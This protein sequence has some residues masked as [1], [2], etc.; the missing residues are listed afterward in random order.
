MRQKDCLRAMHRL[1]S[2]CRCA[3]RE[4]VLQTS[5]LIPA[6]IFTNLITWVGYHS[7][8]IFM[9]FPISRLDSGDLTPISKTDAYLLGA[10]CLKCTRL[11]RRVFHRSGDLS[12]VSSSNRSDLHCCASVQRVPVELSIVV[13]FNLP[14]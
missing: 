3:S 7:Y 5:T 4:K 14:V 9:V 11:C 12:S 6:I 13:T 8:R 2:K 10:S 1:A